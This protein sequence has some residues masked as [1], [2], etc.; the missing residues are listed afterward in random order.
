MDDE[1][2]LIQCRSIG[3]TVRYSGKCRAHRQC[4]LF[5]HRRCAEYTQLPDNVMPVSNAINEAGRAHSLQQIAGSG[6]R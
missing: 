3:H 6:S 4:Y 5:G 2:V 1:I